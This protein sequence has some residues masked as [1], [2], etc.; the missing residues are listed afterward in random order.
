MIDKKFWQSVA[1]NWRKKDDGII[2]PPI[3]PGPPI[4]PDEVPFDEMTDDEIDDIL[5]DLDL[6]I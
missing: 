3:D 4:D 6:D 1:N 5:S 2:T